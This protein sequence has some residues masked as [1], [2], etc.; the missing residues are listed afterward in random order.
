MTEWQE[1]LQFLNT[2]GIG[3]LGVLAWILYKMDKK[4]SEIILEAKH[5]DEKLDEIKNKLD[6]VINNMAGLAG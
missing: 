2:G 6:S 4:V 5:R 3:V 1:I